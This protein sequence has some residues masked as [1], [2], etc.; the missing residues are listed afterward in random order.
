MQDELR[1]IVYRFSHRQSCLLGLWER[2]GD[3]FA[4]C[5]VLVEATLHG[6]QG[7]ITYVPPEMRLFGWQVGDT[8]WKGIVEGRLFAFRAQEL[9]K[10]TGRATGKMKSCGFVEARIGFV[11]AHEIVVFPH[12]RPGIQNTRWIRSGV[13]EKQS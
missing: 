6:L 13:L 8:K 7:R 10:E 9:Y 5:G 12:G 3:S 4:G 11:A 2:V 1:S